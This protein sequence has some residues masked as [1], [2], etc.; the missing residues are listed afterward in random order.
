MMEIDWMSREGARQGLEQLF[1][2][3]TLSMLSA[4]ALT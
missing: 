3:I 2:N 4:P 1:Q